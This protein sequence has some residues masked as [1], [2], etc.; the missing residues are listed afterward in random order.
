LKFPW[1]YEGN[2]KTG[3]V[4]LEQPE[5]TFMGW[6]HASMALKREDVIKAAGL[7]HWLLLEFTHLS[8]KILGM[9]AIPN[10]LICGPCHVFLGGNRA[11]D[12]RLSYLGMANVVDGSNL[13]WLHCIVVWISV[14]IATSHLCC[15]A[16]VHAFEECLVE[17]N[18]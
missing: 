1:S 16:R 8:M 13:Y 18:A 11:G 6:A 7:D 10:L 9:L 4:K 5:Q 2:L 3:Q 15:H 14:W 12:D 17:G